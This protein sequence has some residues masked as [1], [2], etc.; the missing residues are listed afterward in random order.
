VGV[1]SSPMSWKL[2]GASRIIGS[3]HRFGVQNWIKECIECSLS[4]ARKLLSVIVKFS[5]RP[6]LRRAHPWVE[7]GELRKWPW[8]LKLVFFFIF[9]QS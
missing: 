7:A 9:S 4:F 5:V 3:Y 2:R 6:R 8:K 1:F